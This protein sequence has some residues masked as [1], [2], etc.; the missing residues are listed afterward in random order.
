MRAEA[1][2]NGGTLRGTRRGTREGIAPRRHAKAAFRKAAFRARGETH[3]LVALTALQKPP[4]AS[5]G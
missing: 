2:V 3:W 1:R 4:H 5:K